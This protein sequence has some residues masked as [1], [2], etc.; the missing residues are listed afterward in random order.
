M[1]QFL[2]RILC[3]ATTTALLIILSLSAAA[4]SKVT[5]ANRISI[6]GIDVGGKTP[7]QALALL[8]KKYE[9]LLKVTNITLNYNG[10][11]YPLGLNVIK[12]HYDYSA[13]INKACTIV[14]PIVPVKTVSSSDT[15]TDSAVTTEQAVTTDTAI[16]TNSS[17]SP[18]VPAV[19]PLPIINLKLNLVYDKPSINDFLKKLSLKI[20]SNP[21]NSVMT[22]KGKDFFFSDSKNGT[23]LNLTKAASLIIHALIPGK[24]TNLALPVDAVQAKYT[25]DNLLSIKIKDE[26]GEYTT[27]F[28]QSD[29]NR[30]DNIKLASANANNFIVMPGEIFSINKEIGPRLEKNGFKLA[31]VIV[32][33]RF[34]DGIGGGICQVSTTL[35]NAALLADLKIV[36]RDHHSIPSTY[37]PVG[38]DATVS[39]D[40]KDL[41]F[42]NTTSSPLYISNVVDKNKITFKIYGKKDDPNRR[43]KIKTQ[44][45]E[46]KPSKTITVEDPTLPK[47]QSVLD[48]SPHPSYKVRSYREIYE[49][50]HLVTTE[51]LYIDKYP[52]ITGIKKIGTKI[53]LSSN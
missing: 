21:I 10:Q 6:S 37:V 27:W 13:A 4:A 52:L 41:K 31:H 24:T 7:T 43:V 46:Y 16:T 34:V 17:I 5:I 25:K 20:N 2:R 8:K 35:Y 9:P 48:V 19:K 15:T 22:I 45:L 29:V 23:S 26:L 14:R 47:G 33:N 36:E 11:A 51:E 28:R 53:A 38:R 49:K 12:A 39:G 42:Q 50:G 30:V 3:I 32:N 1:K 40:A 44:I 18:N